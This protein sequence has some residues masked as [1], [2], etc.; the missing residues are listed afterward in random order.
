MD[1]FIHAWVVIA[2]R[3]SSRGRARGEEKK[4]KKEKREEKEDN[5]DQPPNVL[6]HTRPSKRGGSRKGKKKKKKKKKMKTPCWLTA[7]QRLQ[8]TLQ[9]IGCRIVAPPVAALVEPLG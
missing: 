7:K 4:T 1:M 5:I 6:R 3:D 8:H 2:R 9:L